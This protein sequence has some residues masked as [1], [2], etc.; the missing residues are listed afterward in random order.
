V[1]QVSLWEG[2]IS[3]VA[4]AGWCVRHDQPPV[5]THRSGDRLIGWVRYPPVTHSM[6]SDALLFGRFSTRRGRCQGRRVCYWQ[7]F[8]GTRHFPQEQ[9]VFAAMI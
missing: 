2:K 8:G 9:A 7:A 6:I 4:E 1:R 5:R 3:G